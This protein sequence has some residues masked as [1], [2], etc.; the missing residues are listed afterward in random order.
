[1]SKILVDMDDVVSVDTAAEQIGISVPTAWRWIRK[2]KLIKISLAGRTL[3]PKTE[4]D[5]LKVA[6]TP[7]T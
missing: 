3:V 4:I 7:A 1:M 5:R 6:K 2:G